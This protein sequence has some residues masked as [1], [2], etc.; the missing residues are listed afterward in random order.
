[1]LSN[2]HLQYITILRPYS[3]DININSSIVDPKSSI[4]TDVWYSLIVN[5]SETDPVE[6][7]YFESKALILFKS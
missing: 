6:H 7:F 2:N 1:M 3:K 5:S 4:G